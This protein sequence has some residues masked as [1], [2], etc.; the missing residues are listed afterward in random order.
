[1]P[2]SQKRRLLIQISTTDRRCPRRFEIKAAADRK[3]TYHT[4][5]EGWEQF[6]RIFWL[7]FLMVY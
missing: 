1:M 6:L 7:W 5:Y 4:I 3:N 2:N